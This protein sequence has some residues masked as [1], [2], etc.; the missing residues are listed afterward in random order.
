MPLTQAVKAWCA[1]LAVT[2]LGCAVFIRWLD[3]PV[4]F[5]FLENVNRL[6]P[7]GTGLSS[8]ILVS[9]EIILMICLAITHMVRGSLPDFARALFIACC[10]SLSALVA[11]DLVQ[12]HQVLVAVARPR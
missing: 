10:A 1:L 8:G 2:L 4:A 9:G 11:N 5:F 7:L 12:C 3:M 6:T